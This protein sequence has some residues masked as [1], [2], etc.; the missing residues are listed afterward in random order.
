MNTH[1]ARASRMRLD[2]VDLRRGFVALFLVLLLA[3][4]SGL[5]L[6]AGFEPPKF[7]DQDEKTVENLAGYP[8]SARHA[9][10]VVAGYPEELLDIQK[11]Q[12][13]SADDFA[14]LLD[15]YPRKT[16]ERIW[17]RLHA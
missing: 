10:L 3:P 1:Q 8:S 7:R 5:A 4:A 6:K 12:Q 11:I 14:A 15:A 17:R 2:R 13:K 16:Q 9:A